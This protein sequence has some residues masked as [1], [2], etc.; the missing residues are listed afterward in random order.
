MQFSPEQLSSWTT[1]G[2]AE[3]AHVLTDD[4]I[5]QLLQVVWR[6]YRCAA[7]IDQVVDCS[8]SWESNA[9]HHS[10]IELRSSKPTA[11]S[12][13]YDRMQ[14]NAVVQG[15]AL[16]RKIASLAAELLG[17][18][19]SSL[20]ASGIIF[21]MDAPLDTRNVL[22]WH[23]DQSYFPANVNGLHSLVVW[24]P[25]Q[26]VTQTTG[27]IRVRPG[28]HREGHI[29]PKPA[30]GTHRGTSQQYAIGDDVS[31]YPETVLEMKA[32][33]GLFFPMTLVHASGPNQGSRMR[34]TLGVRFHR[35]LA[36]DFEPFRLIQTPLHR[37]P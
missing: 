35:A 36:D 5:A 4:E 3:A 8:A 12:A 25:L 32:G 37:K 2:Y 14:T 16:K 19:P 30:E 23:Q 21:R 10:L 20:S 31:H 9:F 11:F 29:A 17:D 18:D 13:I 7:K 6:Q 27:A 34:F 24:I 28:S 33:N 26:D 1:Y 15:M 22:D